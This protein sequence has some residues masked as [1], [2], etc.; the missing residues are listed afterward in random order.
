[1]GC[2]PEMAVFRKFR[3][4]NMLRLLEMQSELVQHEQDYHYI[5]SKDTELDCSIS[6]S[7]AKDWDKLNESLGKGGTRQRD[8][9]RKL[10]KGLDVYSKAAPR[11][12]NMQRVD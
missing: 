4:L 9:W 8:T 6:R 5:C 1:M 3:T 12:E 10:R 2:K 11:T 7:Y